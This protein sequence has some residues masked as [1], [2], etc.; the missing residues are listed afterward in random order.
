MSFTVQAV[1]DQARDLWRE[2]A[3]GDVLLDASCYKWINSGVLAIRSQ[4]PD[5]RFDN[6]TGDAVEYTAVTGVNDSISL[7]SK[8]LMPLAYYL[9]AFGYA[10][11]A[12][13]QNFKA[14]F[15]EY[16]GLFNQSVL[17]A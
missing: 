5:A 14:R 7:D 6:D 9:T 17:T 10:R 12:D 1:I 2:N 8:F 16:M 11:N 13:L 4:R 15:T 3:V